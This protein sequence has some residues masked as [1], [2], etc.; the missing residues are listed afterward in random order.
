MKNRT[1]IGEYEEIT[2]PSE[3]ENKC[4]VCDKE[5]IGRKK[6]NVKFCSF[7]CYYIYKPLWDINNGITLCEK[8]HKKILKYSRRVET[9]CSAPQI[10]DDATVR[11]EQGCSEPN[12]NAL[13]ISLN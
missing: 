8:C 6:W 5:K 10:G 13:A 12:R 7:K 3:L 2:T 11:T 9:E 1:E 4:I